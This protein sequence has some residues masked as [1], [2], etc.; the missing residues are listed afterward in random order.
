MKRIAFA[1]LS[2]LFAAAAFAQTPEEIVSRMDEVMNQHENDGMSIIID[3]KMPILGTMSTKTYWLGDKTRLEA[4][5]MGYKIITWQDG[6]TEW[7]YDSS[8]NEVTI[9]KQ[10]S[11][12]KNEAESDM[13]MLEGITDGYDVSLTKETADAWYLRCKKTRSNTDKDAPKT[14]D[15]AVAKGTYLPISLKAKISG[16]SLTMRDFR[17]GVTEKQVTFDPADFPTA[18]IVDKR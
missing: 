10:E 13:D 9:K 5:V 18:K 11:D 12:G 7:E 16:A 17:F 15:L 14:M 8:S 1:L 2:A 3:V 6:K 4:E